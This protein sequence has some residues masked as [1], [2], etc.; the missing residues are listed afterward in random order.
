MDVRPTLF[1]RL[2]LLIVCVVP[3][4][5]FFLLVAVPSAHAD[6][7]FDDITLQRPAGGGS[8]TDTNPASPKQRAFTELPLPEPRDAG[9]QPAHLYRGPAFQQ[10]PETN[11]NNPLAWLWCTLFGW[12]PWAGC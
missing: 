5:V 10:T 12:L 8:G 9:A 2:R 6:S 7:P 4:S 11:P 1:S 3:I